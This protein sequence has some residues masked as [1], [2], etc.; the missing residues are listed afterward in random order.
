MCEN[1]LL[2]AKNLCR[3]QFV[4]TCVENANSTLVG[5]FTE[6]EGTKPSF[7]SFIGFNA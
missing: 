6:H 7:F 1:I 2:R 5:A 4:F 3:I